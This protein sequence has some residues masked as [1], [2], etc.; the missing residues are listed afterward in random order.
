MQQGHPEHELYCSKQEPPED[1]AKPARLWASTC[2][3]EI[4]WA[5]AGAD[6]KDGCG[7]GGRRE[8]AQVPCKTIT[9]GTLVQPGFR[10]YGL[11]SLETEKRQGLGFPGFTSISILCSV[12]WTFRSNR[13][14]CPSICFLIRI[15]IPSLLGLK[16]KIAPA[17]SRGRPEPSSHTISW[18]PG[19]ESVC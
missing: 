9:C 8:G 6:G 4:L 3:H 16:D 5:N 17:S 14:I 18:V 2:K 15:L 7:G 11:R 13:Y 12:S 19:W 10:I 1:T